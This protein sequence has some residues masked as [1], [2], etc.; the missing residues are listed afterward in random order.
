MVKLSYSSILLLLLVLIFSVVD[1]Q[2][3][4]VD[5]AGKTCQVA[6]VGCTIDAV[7]NQECFQKYNGRGGC[8]RPPGTFIIECMC[9][10]PC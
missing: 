3:M 1:D 10:Y 8:Y 4:K 9:L 5:A 2:I 7:C 6:S